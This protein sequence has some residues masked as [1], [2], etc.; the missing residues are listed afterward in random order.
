MPRKGKHWTRE[1]REIRS[2]SLG[3]HTEETS[4]NRPP[5]SD[6]EYFELSDSPEEDW[7]EEDKE[8][9]VGSIVG[10]EIL[11]N[12]DKRYQVEWEGWQRPDGTS[13][14]WTI[15]L[16]GASD[17]LDTWDTA[18][19]KERRE[20]AAKRPDIDLAELNNYK[21]HQFRTFE[22]AVA[23]EEKRRKWRK[24]PDLWDEW[25]EMDKD[26]QDEERTIVK[27]GSR[28]SVISEHSRKRKRT[29]SIAS[30]SRA[31][32]SRLADE[33]TTLVSSSASINS[34]KQGSISSTSR[35]RHLQ[36]QQPPTPRLQPQPSRRMRLQKHWNE[37]V[38]DIGAA[39]IT[40]VNEVDDEECPTLPPD[41][42]YLENYCTYD[43]NVDDSKTE[44]NKAFMICCECEDGC[45]DP[46]ACSCSEL[47]QCIDE[48]G[49]A[50]T[51]YDSE[52][53]F[54]FHDMRE[55]VE[56]NENCACKAECNNAVAQKPRSIPIQVFKT[57]RNGWGARSPVHIP[58][59][60]ILGFYTGK[61]LRREHLARLP[62]DEREYS[63][64]LD[65]RDDEEDLPRY[66]VCA[67]RE[68]NWT[69]FVNHSCS[70]NAIVYSMV[71]DAPV[72]VNMPYIVLA[73]TEDIPAKKEI[74][75]DYN[76]SAARERAAAPTGRKKKG[77]KKGKRLEEIKMSGPA[78]SAASS[79][80][81]S[82]MNHPAGPKTV[83]FWAP[84]MKWCLV[85]AGVKDYTRPAEKLSVSQNVAL[86]AT[87]FIWV[88]YSLVIT[89]I[90]YSLA[91]VNFFVG[92]TGLGQLARIWE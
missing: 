65:I 16:L 25:L 77:K 43:V 12:R 37:V 69:R 13:T 51:A 1:K 71:F 74:T 48:H 19:A 22:C 17:L 73:A 11:Q 29:E 86:A 90:N 4:E 54:L 46:T 63:F 64:D 24:K 89:P 87:G 75:I 28:A 53:L 60:T 9:P 35:Y 20:K 15:G 57:R 40:L 30:G 36:S 38:R 72:D 80:F 2:P 62:A 34:V 67:Y 59:G 42:R 88:R 50:A 32:S 33:D 5:N 70:P 21:P 58:R 6:Y 31:S 10:E 81:Q 52:G 61:I 78:A 49:E 56:C 39:K 26:D 83:F 3:S 45:V 92:A 82:F 18:R 79:R 76:P 7:G 23:Y 44:D 68:G 41:F 84:L 91:A 47:S 55:V 14:T 8:W 66:S 27:E 85:A